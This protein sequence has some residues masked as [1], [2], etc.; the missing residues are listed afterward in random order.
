MRTLARIYVDPVVRGYCA[1]RSG[2]LL[3]SLS[4]Y[5]YINPNGIS[6]LPMLGVIR[7]LLWDGL[8]SGLMWIGLSRNALGFA[9]FATLLHAFGIMLVPH[10]TLEARMVSLAADAG[11]LLLQI[12]RIVRATEPEP[13]P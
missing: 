7:S 6:A 2:F 13:A 12:V 1:L 11:I 4:Y 10:V 8:W 5:V 3:F 9:I